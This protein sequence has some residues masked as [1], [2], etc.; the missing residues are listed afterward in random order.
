M[1]ASRTAFGSVA[2][3]AKRF[4]TS[5]PSSSN[6]SA[7]ATTCEASAEV[8]HPHRPR[9]SFFD[10]S[11]LA[12]EGGGIDVRLGATDKATEPKT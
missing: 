4:T 8:C 11:R 1:T 5:T 6:A 3:Q 12:G 7:Q 9:L 2:R 10:D